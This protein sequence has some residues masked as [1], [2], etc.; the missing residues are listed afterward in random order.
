MS[1]II[2][3]NTFQLESFVYDVYIFKLTELKVVFGCFKLLF[4]K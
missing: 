4:H 1:E 2:P 3:S